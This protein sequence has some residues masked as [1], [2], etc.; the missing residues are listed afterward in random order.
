MGHQVANEEALDREGI[1]A[2]QRRKL[3]G[4][5]REV[6]AANPFYQRKLAG[7][8][9]DAAGDPL[10][11]LPFTTRAEIQQDQLDHPPYGTNLTYARERYVRL[12]QTSGSTATPLRWLDT[13]DSWAWFKACWKTL[14]S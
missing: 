8:S 14:Y 2:F 4:M 11:C 13:A 5:L 6:R 1:G 7:V 12:H 10:D 9:F 3:A